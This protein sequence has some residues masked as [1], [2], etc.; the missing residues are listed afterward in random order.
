MQ[1]GPVPGVALGPFAR[2]IA[3]VRESAPQGLEG[4]V[5]SFIS[6]TRLLVHGHAWG[7]L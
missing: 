3:S 5:L 2:V 6:I 4:Q 1:A 7:L